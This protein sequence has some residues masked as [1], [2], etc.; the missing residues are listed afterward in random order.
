MK[1]K[2]RL[3][4]LIG[5]PIVVLLLAF[6]LPFN[7]SKQPDS[8]SDSTSGDESSVF[9]PFRDR[10]AE[11]ATD[12][13]SDGLA[14]VS[15]RETSLDKIIPKLP[16]YIEDFQTSVGLATTINIYR[17]SMDS[18]D[19]IRL[20]IHNVDYQRKAINHNDPNMVAFKES[21]LKAKEELAG[22]GIDLSELKLRFGEQPYVRETAEFWVEHL[23]LL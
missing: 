14:D 4:L 7:A 12:D 9:S 5:V 11:W 20:E 18:W 3:I 2:T 1:R 10:G 16:M 21:F 22:M 23:D 19:L 8:T 6:F 13:T 15:V 17:T